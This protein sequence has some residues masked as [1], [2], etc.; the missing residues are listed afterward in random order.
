M[1]GIQRAVDFGRR[2]SEEPNEGPSRR[3]I[4]GNGLED[5]DGV[6]RDSVEEDDGREGLRVNLSSLLSTSGNNTSEAE[7]SSWS[8]GESAE[9]VPGEEFMLSEESEACAYTVWMAPL[10]ALMFLG[11]AT[12][13]L[14]LSESSVTG[15]GCMGECWGTSK[16]S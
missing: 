8:N 5:V 15:L 3:R 9:I 4:Q 16:F 2:S 13:E 11:P 12:V 10:L 1:E 6:T 14:P 7:M